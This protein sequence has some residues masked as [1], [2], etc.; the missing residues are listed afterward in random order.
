MGKV[1]ERKMARS[2][3]GTQVRGKEFKTGADGEVWRRKRFM[4]D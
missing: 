4:G 3:R 2:P 1:G